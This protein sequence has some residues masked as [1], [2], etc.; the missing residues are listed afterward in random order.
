MRA[1]IETR[2]CGRTNRETMQVMLVSSSGETRFPMPPVTL[3]VPLVVGIVTFL[4]S[5]L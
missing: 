1:D 4:L 5:L 3:V 2:R